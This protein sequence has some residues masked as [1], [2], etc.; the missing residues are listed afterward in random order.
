[1]NLETIFQSEITFIAVLCGGSFIIAGIILYF[2]PPKNIN[3][4]Y[5][6]RTA[7][8]MKSQENWDFAQIYSAQKAILSGIILCIVGILAGFVSMSENLQ[9]VIGLS[10]LIS[11][12]IYLFISTEKALKEKFHNN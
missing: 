8:S 1:M 11:F 10:I 3:G 9:I 2:F 12:C 5:G 6:Y 4:L 7:A